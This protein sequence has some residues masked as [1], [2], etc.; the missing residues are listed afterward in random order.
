[1][2]NFDEIIDRRG[3]NALFVG[4]AEGYIRLSLAMPRSIIKT[5]LERMRDSIFQ[6]RITAVTDTHSAVS[7]PETND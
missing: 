3:T 4:N 6:W 1:M 5:G 2:Y 7:R